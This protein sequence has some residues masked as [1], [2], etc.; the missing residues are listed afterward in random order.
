MILSQMLGDVSCLTF[1]AYTWLRRVYYTSRRFIENC[2][3]FGLSVFDYY[4]RIKDY[5]N[6]KELF[7][8]GQFY[9]W[10][11]DYVTDT[12]DSDSLVMMYPEYCYNTF[13]NG[14]KDILYGQFNSPDV[15]LMIADSQNY[16]IS[17]HLTHF[18]NAY[19]DFK[20]LSDNKSIYKQIKNYI[21]AKKCYEVD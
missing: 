16:Y 7:V 21:Y 9:Q 13:G 6:K 1:E 11:S 8:L 2:K 20:S 4:Q 15:C 17:N 19:L 3:R 18:K 5:W 14:W 12:K 10:Q